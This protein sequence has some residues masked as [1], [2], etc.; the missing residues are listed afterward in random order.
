MK[1]RIGLKVILFFVQFDESDGKYRQTIDKQ[2]FK[3][4]NIQCIVYVL[5]ST[6]HIILI[7]WLVPC[8]GHFK[9]ITALIFV[10]VCGKFY[11]FPWYKYGSY[12]H[13][14]VLRYRQDA[15]CPF[16]WNKKC[17]QRDA[18][19]YVETLSF[20]KHL[21]FYTKISSISIYSIGQAAFR[22]W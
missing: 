2:L 16:E 22:F 15:Q 21:Q 13:R 17:V 7:M 1:S 11:R 10:S 18:G 14:S 8:F 12:Q 19:D 9:G 20:P 4:Y 6:N 3:Y 5:N